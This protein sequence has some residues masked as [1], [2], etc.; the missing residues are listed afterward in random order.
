MRIVFLCRKVVDVFGKGGNS[1]RR[2][3]WKGRIDR[4]V[5]MTITFGWDG[6]R[7]RFYF[8]YL[9]YS[10]HTYE[11]DLPVFMDPLNSFLNNPG[12]W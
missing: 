10:I 7:R 3:R 2:M 1:E 8:T 5:S 9:G 12:T 4:L 11:Y 6:T